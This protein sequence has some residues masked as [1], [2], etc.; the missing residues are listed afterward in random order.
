MDWRYEATFAAWA[1]AGYFP[2]KI[3]ISSM[4]L[5]FSILFD[6]IPQYDVGFSQKILGVNPLGGSC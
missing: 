6:V 1:F 4:F 2:F 5:L 3:S